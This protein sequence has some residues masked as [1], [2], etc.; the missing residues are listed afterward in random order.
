M[1]L[2]EK[3]ME[4]FR[5]EREWKNKLY[6]AVELSLMENKRKFFSPLEIAEEVARRLKVPASS[7]SIEDIRKIARKVHENLSGSGAILKNGEH[8]SI[9]LIIREEDQAEFFGYDKGSGTEW[10]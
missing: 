1:P 9:Y 3:K 8:W 10:G 5:K 4:K 6:K 2:S 7:I